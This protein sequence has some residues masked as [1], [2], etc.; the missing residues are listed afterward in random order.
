MGETSSRSWPTGIAPHHRAFHEAG[1]WPQRTVADHAEALAQERGG[2]LC[3]IDGV[4]TLTFAEVWRDAGALAAGLR[5]RGLKPGDVVAFQL[6]N[7][8]EAA[9]LNIAAALSGLVVN[10]IVPI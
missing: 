9:V 3:L 10:P 7:W 4:G 5:G 8:R 2:D 1:L 6:P